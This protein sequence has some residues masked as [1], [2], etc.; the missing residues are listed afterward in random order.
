MGHVYFKLY[1][2]GIFTLWLM[3]YLCGLFANGLSFVYIVQWYIINQL[4][5]VIRTRIEYF[6]PSAVLASENRLNC[7]KL[8]NYQYHVTYWQGLTQNVMYSWH[9]RKTCF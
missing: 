5:P 3:G 9:R 7:P 2:Y 8:I 4:N 6:L 1:L